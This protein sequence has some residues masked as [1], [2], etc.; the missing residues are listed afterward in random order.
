MQGWKRFLCASMVTC[1]PLFLHSIGPSSD[2]SL[3]AYTFEIPSGLD[4]SVF[5]QVQEI[6]HQI[7]VLNE[8]KRKFLSQSKFHEREAW[9]LQRFDVL[10]SRYEM[11]LSRGYR[12]KA[13]AT[14]TQINE[15]IESRESLIEPY[16]DKP[17][18]ESAVDE[19]I[20]TETHNLDFSIPEPVD[21]SENQQNFQNEIDSVDSEVREIELLLEEKEHTEDPEFPPV[22]ELDTDLLNF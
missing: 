7:E 14:D 3:L 16:L 12:S 4:E 8:H 20:E 18:V 5:I 13:E 17:N 11:D 10:R 2:S 22:P 15:L 21:S 19:E 6:D 1:I 9:R